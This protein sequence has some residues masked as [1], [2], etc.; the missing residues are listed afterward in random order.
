MSVYSAALMALSLCLTVASAQSQ[1]RAAIVTGEV[2]NPPSREI[3]VSGIPRYYLV[4]SQ[5][6]IVEK[7]LRVWDVDEIVAKIEEQ[8]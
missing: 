2:H 3:D 7:F 5:G 1:P 8:L 4:D 6:L